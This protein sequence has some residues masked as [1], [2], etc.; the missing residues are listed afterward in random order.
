M[1]SW[2]ENEANGQNP[3]NG[4][5][6]GANTTT[7]NNTGA[8]FSLGDANTLNQAVGWSSSTS[9]AGKFVDLIN[10]AA[11]TKPQL[12]NLR[13]GVVDKLTGDYGSAA[14]VS[15]DYDGLPLFG[16][17]LFERGASLRPTEN[18]GHEDYF[19][20]TSLAN[21][22]VIKTVAAEIKAR[23]SLSADPVFVITNT[24]PSLHTTEMTIE[25]SLSIMGQIVTTIFGRV[26]GLL[27]ALKV[28]KNDKFT[29]TVGSMQ[30]APSPIDVNGHAARADLGIRLQHV[31]TNNNTT[32]TLLNSNNANQYPDCA[33]AAYINLRYVGPKA[34]QPQGTF[35]AKQITPEV[36][37][38]LMDSSTLNAVAPF[39]R[40][41][42]MLNAATLIASLGGWKDYVKASLDKNRK[43][44]ALA[45]NLIW[46]P[47]MDTSDMK[48]LDKAENVDTVLNY[49][50]HETASVVVSHRAGNGIGGLSSLLAEIATGSANSLKQLLNILDNM[51]PKTSQGLTFSQALSK[52]FAGEPTLSAGHII[53]SAIPTISG[54][55]RG[56]KGLASLADMDL[57]SVATYT[58][59]KR[60][61]F[62]NYLHAQSYNNRVLTPKQQRIY[63]MKLA[64]GMYSSNDMMVT[65][66]SIDMIINPVFGNLLQKFTEQTGNFQIFGV[67]S[68]IGQN[69]TAFYNTTGEL[70]NLSNVGGVRANTDFGLNQ[71]N[72]QFNL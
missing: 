8:N 19:S 35:D 70:F 71:F 54:V 43:L 69:D 15:S 55:Y 28:S 67:N 5:S 3:G 7:A 51:F 14:Y 72:S 13:Y 52:S 33:A 61:D 23:Y 2:A 16:I 34:N 37:L 63:L 38:S 46:G 10:K 47:G 25:R 18:N 57:L 26:P 64:A 50:C 39:E 12:K 6:V 66:E 42:L 59:D 11:E 9:D 41:I 31:P 30:A 32:P 45:Q 60:A 36:V 65:G 48:Q 27:G 68:S 17:I 49:F 58:G 62:L 40:Q 29:A 44:S 20:I 21:A 4:A 56:P 24:V 53:S 1:I 22:D